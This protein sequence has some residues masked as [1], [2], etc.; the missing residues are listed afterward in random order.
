MVSNKLLIGTSKGLYCYT[1]NSIGNL[2]E[3][4]F[5]SQNIFNEHPVKNICI[6][7][8]NIYIASNIFVSL[9]K[10]FSSYTILSENINDNWL[11]EI[12]TVCS[13][14]YNLL[15]LGCNAGLAIFDK[16]ASA[17]VSTI[18]DE[19][20]YNNKLKHLFGIH[21]LDNGATL[22]ATQN[23]LF[24]VGNKN[25][26]KIIRSEGY[27]QNVSNID[28]NENIV[29]NA[30]GIK[31][32]KTGKLIPIENV[33]PEFYSFKNWKINNCIQF[34]DSIFIL[35]TEN[36][37]GILLWNKLR[38]SITNINTNST[39]IKLK[40]NNVNSIFLDEKR[41]LWVLS[42]FSITIID[43]KDKTFVEIDNPTSKTKQAVG[44]F[45]DMVEI[46]EEFWVASYGVGILI[47]DKKYKLKSIISQNE[48]LC[49]NGVY[50]IF[51]A[52]SSI[53]VSS[54]NGIS[55][56]DAGTL[57]IK[58]L[59]YP[60]DGLHGNSFEEACGAQVNGKIYFGGL[61]GFTI[62]DPSK[63]KDNLSSPKLY[64]EEINI[65]T[66]S[67]KIDTTNL[68]ITNLQIPN[69]V[70]QTKISFIGL[71]YQNPNRVNY[72]YKINELGDKWIDLK[73]QN[74]ITL[75]GIAPGKYTLQVKAANE[76]AV[77]CAPVSMMLHF[78]PKW[79][80]TLL[81]KILLAILIAASLF[82][83]Y[84]FRIR[85]L[86]KVLAVRQKISQNLHD[87]IGSTL[88]A[89]NMYTQVAKLQPQSNI[90][91]NIIEENTQDA[92]GKLDDIIW[93]T[94]PKN[95]KIKNLVE[96][97]DGFA[98]P[99]LQ[100][101]NIQFNFTHSN[102]INEQK[103]G[104]ATRQNLFFIFK[105]AINNVVKYADC[106]NCTVV[107][108]DKNKYIC[109]SIIDDGKGFDPTQPTERN[110]ILNMQ[111]RAKEMKGSFKIESSLLAGT[112]VVVRLPV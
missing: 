17:I 41:K 66:A 59:F 111:L 99:L 90:L 45:F 1:I 64:F 18:N 63:L 100:A 108:E 112:K 50:K 68:F 10:D 7:G 83:L 19:K 96:R 39:P 58:N 44:L 55:K 97:M 34:N 79:Y 30:D 70:T 61:D 76:D 91:I 105:E 86:R 3:F 78:L 28:K 107:F 36:N 4:N 12:N 52:G 32:Y 47:L 84:S 16:S 62:I 101:K 82:I 95:D 29:S 37:K 31:C 15:A 85:Q 94:N 88:S 38:R 40:S 5:T 54:N 87:D 73:N 46:N 6:F 23:G 104:E 109:C 35:G 27:F 110:G 9:K 48:G 93:S 51:K 49:N 42:D 92:L 77:E 74:F 71:N 103:I 24:E 106:K 67:K 60:N 81:F 22:S 26:L 25:Y 43:L 102:I 14:D 2:T 8:D 57:K 69:N 98:R 13:L 80:Q 21:P 11:S 75:I 72:W 20:H 65:E 89:I 56:I 33:Y 53:F